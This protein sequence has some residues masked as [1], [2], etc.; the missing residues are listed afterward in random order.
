MREVCHYSLLMYPEDTALGP[1]AQAT[2][3]L[4]R[5]FRWSYCTTSLSMSLEDG[6]S[7]GPQPTSN[8]SLDIDWSSAHA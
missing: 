1:D 6:L 7:R 3:Q 8:A 2:F 4:G 5:H